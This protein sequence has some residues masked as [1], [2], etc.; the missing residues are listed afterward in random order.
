MK[1]RSFLLSLGFLLAPNI[2]GASS[3]TSLR[4]RARPLASQDK[5]LSRLISDSK[6]A[7]EVGL[8]CVTLDQ[9]KLVEQKNANSAFAPASVLKIFTALYALDVLGKDFSYETRVVH[10]GQLRDGI[11]HGNLYLIG[12]GD[13]SFD[14]DMM[15]SLV[16]SITEKGIRGVTGQFYYCD[17][18]SSNIPYIDGGQRPQAGY[19][20]SVG[21]LNLNFNRIFFEWRKTGNKT[22]VSLD[23]RGRTHRPK[24]KSISLDV[25]AEQTQTYAYRSDATSERWTVAKR[26]LRKDG[27]VWLPVRQPGRYFAEVF[28][29]LA[30]DMGLALPD[31]KPHHLPK[32]PVH[33]IAV[34][35]SAPLF[36]IVRYMLKHS[37]NLS[38]ECLGRSATQALG[39][40][41][42]NLRASAMRMQ[43]WATI[44][45]GLKDAV[46]VDHSGL[47][48]A[49]RISAKS[50]CAGLVKANKLWPSFMPLLRSIRPR[51]INGEI[52]ETVPSSIKAKTGTLYFVSSLAGYM[53][54]EGKPPMAFAIFSQNLEKRKI[55]KANN[56]LERPSGS[57]TWNRTA[58]SLQHSLLTRWRLL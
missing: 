9:G 40:D 21:G 16:K 41:T 3:A 38:A 46:F 36:S 4:P 19:N 56:P 1:R 42:S 7:G 10:D 20:P 51:D 5:S 54:S 58:R 39:G 17:G 30:K 33:K 8:C 26:S 6:L 12:Q 14:T 31:P 48:E 45:L 22:Q 52:D 49:S 35:K 23:A 29:F 50:M 28:S 27:A 34:H 18:L 32:V 47:G 53:E 11:I 37:M 44:W 15:V 2:G 55:W 24:V 57:K 13:P 43:E 25:S